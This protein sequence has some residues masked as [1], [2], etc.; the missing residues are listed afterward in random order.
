MLAQLLEFYKLLNENED[1][2]NNRG[3]TP[4]AFMD[5]YRSQPLEPE[6]YEYF[7][8]PAIFIDYTMQGQGVKSP[9]LVTM[10]IHV[11]T[12]EMPDASNIATQRLDGIKRF[13]Y[14]LTLQ[15]ILE[16]SMLGN[17]SRLKFLTETLLD[18]PVVNYHMQTYEFEAY[19]CDMIG[20]NPD[21]IIGEFEKIGIFGSLYK[22]LANFL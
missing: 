8:L 3:I 9:R 22:S 4:I 19:L 2:F 12:D 15:E 21:V 13:L 14:N 11:V 20:E 6:L 1:K 5:I 7:P 17:T 10:T 18:A 16:N